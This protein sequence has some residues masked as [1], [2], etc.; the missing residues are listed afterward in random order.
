[1]EWR[2]PRGPAVCVWLPQRAHGLGGSAIQHGQLL[3]LRCGRAL[4]QLL[5]DSLASVF[6]GHP[7]TSPSQNLWFLGRLSAVSLLNLPWRALLV[8]PELT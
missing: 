7:P 3:L 6:L 8:A 2:A 1:M 5:S 4:G